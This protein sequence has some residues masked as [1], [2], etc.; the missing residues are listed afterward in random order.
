MHGKKISPCLAS[1]KLATAAQQ[2]QPWQLIASAFVS[3]SRSLTVTFKLVVATSK[4]PDTSHPVKSLNSLGR[5]REEKRR[6]RF[7]FE[8]RLSQ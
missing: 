7:A 6:A 8:T 3:R 1:D 4:Q 2:R 5:Q